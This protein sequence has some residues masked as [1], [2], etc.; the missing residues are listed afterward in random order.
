MTT[1]C[2]FL[3]GSANDRPLFMRTNMNP[4][5]IICQSEQQKKPS[6]E[7]GSEKLGRTAYWMRR[8]FCF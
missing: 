6:D 2:N 8:G 5:L 4:A 7:K 1:S 3:Q